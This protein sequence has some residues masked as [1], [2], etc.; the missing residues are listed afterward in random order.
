MVRYVDH[1]IVG[2][3]NSANLLIVESALIDF[4]RVRGLTF[5]DVAPKYDEKIKRIQ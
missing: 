5:N 4:L 3:K 2:V 1:I